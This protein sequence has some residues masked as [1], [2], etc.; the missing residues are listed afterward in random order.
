MKEQNFRSYLEELLEGKITAIASNKHYPKDSNI[1]RINFLVRQNDTIVLEIM[2]LT[3][4]DDY[5]IEEACFLSSEEVEEYQ[6]EGQEGSV[7]L[8]MG[9]SG[10]DKPRMPVYTMDTSA[11]GSGMITDDDGGNMLYSCKASCRTITGSSRDWAL[12]VA[13]CLLFFFQ[14]IP[15]SIW[16][17]NPDTE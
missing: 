16:L 8:K 3:I 9:G 5:K 1:Q 17:H 12:C 4:S 14:P 11:G 7:R 15:N 10:P 13:S 2:E 6:V